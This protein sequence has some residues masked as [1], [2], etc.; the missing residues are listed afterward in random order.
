MT[1]DPQTQQL[2]DDLKTPIQWTT[3][4]K[5]M[6]FLIILGFILAIFALGFKL[7]YL[8]TYQDFVARCYCAGI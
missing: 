8:V 7:G 6:F 2:L 4:K 5:I 1:T 3:P